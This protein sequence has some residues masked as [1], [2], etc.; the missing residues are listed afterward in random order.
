MPSR[1]SVI[2]PDQAWALIRLLPPPVV[3]AASCARMASMALCRLVSAA[4]RL[5]DVAKGPAD[6]KAV[7]EGQRGVQPRLLDVRQERNGA[8]HLGR[9]LEA[10]CLQGRYRCFCAVKPTIPHRQ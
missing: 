1:R 4:V 3:K 8:C 10:C 9:G 6:C 2:S 5:E 7:P